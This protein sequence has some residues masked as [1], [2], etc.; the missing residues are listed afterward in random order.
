[1]W[2][3][4]LWAK[5]FVWLLLPHSNAPESLFHRLVCRAFADLSEARYH[6]LHLSSLTSIAEALGAYVNARLRDEEVAAAAHTGLR[7]YPSVHTSVARS[8][9]AFAAG[10]RNYHATLIESG[11]A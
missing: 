3:S 2:D 11:R 9:A 5:V 7:V 8:V 6:S 1:M 10:L 4:K